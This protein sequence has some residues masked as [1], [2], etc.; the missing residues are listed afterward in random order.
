MAN[1]FRAMM[2]NINVSEVMSKSFVVVEQNANVSDVQVKFKDSRASHVL[3][4]DESQRLVG[5]V[6]Q[7]YL[8]KTQSPRKMLSDDMRYSADTIIDGDSFYSKETLD[9]YILKRI[10]MKNPFSLN[11]ESNVVDA[12]LNM[13]TRTIGCVPVVDDRRKI[14]GVITHL[15]IVEF[16]GRILIKK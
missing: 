2:E 13:A 15:E 7:K 5:L 12:I 11:L 1:E 16:M 14:K 8:Y 4:I 6:S 3:V 10:M 9:S